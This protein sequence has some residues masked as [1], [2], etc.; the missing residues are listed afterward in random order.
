MKKKAIWVQFFYRIQIYVIASRLVNLKKHQTFDI[1][2]YDIF[3][4]IF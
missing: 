3:Y 2:A 4:M 1:F